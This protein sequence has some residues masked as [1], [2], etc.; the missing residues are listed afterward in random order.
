[1]PIDHDGS[2]I[3]AL[4]RKHYI[5]LLELA[6]D[7]ANTTLGLDA[8]FDLEM[9]EVQDVLDTLAKQIRNVADTTRADVQR[10]TGQAA[11]HGWSPQTWH[12]RY[13]HS[14]RLPVRHARS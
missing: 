3:A 14:G 7:D 13:G 11:E 12:A 8:A 4:M 5:Q 1:V 9:P 10:L 2:Q 6:T